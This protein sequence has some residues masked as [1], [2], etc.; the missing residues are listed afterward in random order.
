MEMKRKARENSREKM[1]SLLP[2]IN[3]FIK[4]C[5][6]GGGH[7]QFPGSCFWSSIYQKLNL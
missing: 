6:G 4:F 5:E 2:E 3:C 1:E 7:I